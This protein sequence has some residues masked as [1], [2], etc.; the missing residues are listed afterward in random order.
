[1]FASIAQFRDWT[2]G[3]FDPNSPFCSFPLDSWWAYA[4]YIYMDRTPG[5]ENLLQDL[6]WTTT[7]NFLEGPISPTFWLGSS[8]AYTPGHFDTYGVN[9]VVEIFGRKQW[10]LFPYS[11]T[12]YLY[13]T[14]LPLE[15]STVFSEINL[16]HLNIQDFP[17]LSKSS[18]RTIILDPGDILFVPRNWWHFVRSADD[19]AVTC[20]VN[21]WIDQPEVDNRVRLREA[22]TQLAC[23][24]LF[25]SCPSLDS[26]KYIHPDERDLL[27]SNWWDGLLELI[28]EL[29]RNETELHSVGPP[30]SVKCG[31]DSGLWTSLPSMDPIELFG[32][33]DIQPTPHTA[34]KISAHSLD[35]AS[36]NAEASNP[37]INGAHLVAE[38]IRLRCKF[39]AGQCVIDSLT[40]ESTLRDLIN[41][42]SS[43]VG[44]SPARL[45]LFHGYPPKQIQC[46]NA[47]LG[48][49]LNQIPLRSGDTITV[50]TSRVPPMAKKESPEQSAET[51]NATAAVSQ[52]PTQPKAAESASSKPQ[53]PYVVRL[54][55]PSDNSCLFTSVLF[56]VENADGHQPIDTHVVTNIVAV[57]QLR[58]LIASIVMS[59]PERYSE[60]FLG[61]PNEVYCQQIQEPDRWGGGIEVA[62]L[63]QVYEL[64]ICMVDIQSGRIDR[65]GED[66]NY[67]D[68]ILLIYDGI[69]YDP[70][71]LARPDLG[72]LIS[73]FST[74]NDQILLDSQALAAE[75]RAAWSFTDISS[76]TLICRQCQQPL[77]G[78]SGA[79]KH[80]KET[81]HTEFSEIPCS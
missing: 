11:D 28:N 50:D 16:S 54:T 27:S 20:A 41:S 70:L 1:M 76:F 15:E 72:R 8:G 9:L 6:A 65:F 32:S 34:P 10:T 64:E 55:A 13:A 48:Q 60:A 36:G 14:R 52:H 33:V 79:Q 51:T 25:S 73:V 35:T 61:V 17:L 12:P 42:I 7:F 24:S 78:Q 46:S 43:I 57:T 22:L 74:K 29:K 44:I 71:A 37:L 39:N 81:G 26:C 66:R 21:L 62:I 75:A 58:E 69:H 53:N 63:S 23:F 77:I 49:R 30:S 5:F 31:D 38:P 19:S 45:T 3:I 56:C 40:S 59:D 47:D 68:R 4:G 2:N 67:R 18:P 80:A